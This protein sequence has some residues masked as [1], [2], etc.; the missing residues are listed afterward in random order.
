MEDR[1]ITPEEEEI[2]YVDKSRVECF[3]GEIGG[4]SYFTVYTM[5]I[6]FI[7]LTHP[8]SSFVVLLIVK[9]RGSLHVHCGVVRTVGS[10]E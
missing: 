10:A 6:L 5:N 4:G 7:Q 9:L 2:N 1:R 3:L 8:L